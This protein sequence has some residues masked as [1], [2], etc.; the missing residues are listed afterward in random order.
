MI[1]HVLAR[2]Y[3]IM[4]WL[5]A[6][7]CVAVWERAKSFKKWQ[8]HFFLF[9]GECC[10]THTA[11][12][13]ATVPLKGVAYER[14]ATYNRLAIFAKK[15]FLLN[16]FSLTFVATVFFFIASQWGNSEHCVLCFPP[17][18]FS[19]KHSSNMHIHSTLAIPRE[20]VCWDRVFFLPP[21]LDFF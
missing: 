5:C 19:G 3:F 2:T 12:S 1:G 10:A 8:M 16:E 17:N 15:F 4:G 20:T 6:G 18:W 9:L 13:R 14:A 21:V 7:Y 11:R